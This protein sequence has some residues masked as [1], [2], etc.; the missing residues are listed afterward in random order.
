MVIVDKNEFDAELE[1]NPEALT[2][3]EALN[4]TVR[5]R[6]VGGLAVDT[7]SLRVGETGENV[8]M[9][10]SVRMTIGCH[11]NLYSFYLFSPDLDPDVA[12]TTNVK[13]KDD[14]AS[15]TAERANVKLYVVVACIA[16]LVLVAI[17]Q[18]SCT[19]FKMSRRGSS[20]QKVSGFKLPGL[21]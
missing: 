3:Q 2:V 7:E 5:S 14:D 12:V 19:I 6:R 9:I 20:V 4:R 17:I 11:C 18:A 1:G 15:K 13:T 16:A 10:I 21:E 8:K